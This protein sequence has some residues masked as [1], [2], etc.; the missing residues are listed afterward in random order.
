MNLWLQGKY[1]QGGKT[2]KSLKKKKNKEKSVQ[3]V[4][5]GTRWA[6]RGLTGCLAPGVSATVASVWWICSQP[7]RGGY[8]ESLACQR[9]RRTGGETRSAGRQR[10]CESLWSTV[11]WSLWGQGPWLRRMHHEA[12]LFKRYTLFPH[13]LEVCLQGANFFFFKV[14]FWLL[15]VIHVAYFGSVWRKNTF[16][17]RTKKTMYYSGCCVK[18]QRVGKLDVSRF[19]MTGPGLWLKSKKWKGTFIT[20]QIITTGSN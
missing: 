12:W 7:V 20:T 18:L 16:F 15:F 19:L 17:K 13:R 3:D 14:D 2:R 9:G 1:P 5:S 11:N 10:P 4:N 8:Q 6:K